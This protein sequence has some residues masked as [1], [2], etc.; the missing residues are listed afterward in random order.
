MIEELELINHWLEDKDPSF[1]TKQGLDASYFL[2]SRDIVEF[3]FDYLQQTGSTPSPELVNANFEEFKILT[4]LDSV[5]Y[6][7]G[8]LK[9]QKLYMEYRPV[10]VKNAEMLSEGK[11]T[12][13]VWDMKSKVD[14]LLRRFTGKLTHYD[15]VKD[16]LL[17]LNRYMEKHG[18]EGI[19]GVPTGL[20]KLDELTGGLKED[21]MLL[22]TARTNEGK[23]L[24]AS[25]I[26]YVA[27]KSFQIAGVGSPVLYISTEMPELEVSYRLDTLRSHFSNRELNTGGL[28]DPDIYK[29]YLEELSQKDTSFVILSTDSNGGRSFTPADIHALIEQYKP[30]LLVI[31][32]LY[33][34][35]DGT[36]ERDIR[37]RIV[38]VSNQL[39]DINLLTKTPTILVSQAGRDAAREAKRDTEATP[40]LYHIQESDN[41]AQKATLVLSLRLMEDKFK[42]TLRK[43]RGGVKDVDF[44]VKVD[45]DKG[46]W[47]ECDKEEMY[48]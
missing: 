38:N 35:S 19:S 40:E 14:K 42:M 16:A 22:I 12:E 13:A 25:F 20:K 31:D 41:P 11:T 43:N 27:W 32:Q 9:E 39:R 48:F 10:L 15:W 37:K 17:R 23:S 33:D 46:F 8:A 26:A 2:P 24:V 34:I 7:V 18:Q 36:G 6:L 28:P 3:V 30:G 21:D 1:L 5:D 29:E 45:I 4:D 47:E 44:Y